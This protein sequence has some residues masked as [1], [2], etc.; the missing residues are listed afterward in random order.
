M[1]KKKKIFVLI[2]PIWGEYIELF[3]S[4]TFKSL[5]FD[6][7][8]NFLKKNSNLKFIFCTRKK[9]KNL[10]DG[11]IPDIFDRE[12]CLID[13][14]L[15]KEPRK[16]HLH[17]S[18][19]EGF[20]KEKRNHKNINF[21]LLTADDFFASENLKYLF[22]LI[23]NR[24]ELNLIL[25]NKIL[26]NHELFRKKIKI[27]LRK[28]N[29]NKKQ[30]VK[31][32]F[33]TM[34]NFSKYSNPYLSK[35]NYS[36]YNLVFNVDK[37]NK[38]MRSY[39]MHPLLIRPKTKITKMESFIDYYLQPKYVSSFKN[40]YFI[41]NSNS[42]V[43][44]GIVNKDFSKSII[45]KFQVN[46]FAST[47]SRWVTQYHKKYVF[48]ETLFTVKKPNNKNL[49]TIKKTSLKL[50]NKIDVILKNKNQSYKKHPYWISN[51]PGIKNIMKDNL[52]SKIVYPILK[53]F[54]R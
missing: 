20:K 45:Y 11:Q 16:K 5:L 41:K 2:V 31:L 38:L 32:S 13:R 27:F 6:G 29:I 35:F 19:L 18:Y 47:L 37:N 3:F 26:V 34:D 4:L 21:L 12:Y 8:L 40:I 10:I 52:K 33:L 46:K 22:N 36:T 53:L 25:E 15:E 48:H 9:D 43:R 23:K 50:V 51:E 28:K 1:N 39:L 24:T 17:K 54:L 7:N 44:V 42:F 14:V 49:K 30:L